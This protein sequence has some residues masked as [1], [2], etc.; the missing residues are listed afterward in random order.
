[1]LT[2]I[3]KN[4]EMF[5]LSSSEMFTKSIDL[6]TLVCANVHS[7]QGREF[8]FSLSVHDCDKAM[9]VCHNAKRFMLK[10]K[11]TQLF[12]WKRLNMSNQCTS[13]YV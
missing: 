12:V 6:S 8:H 13:I 10:K 3:K 1:M 11:R 7:H 4:H 5:E 2:Y 9:A